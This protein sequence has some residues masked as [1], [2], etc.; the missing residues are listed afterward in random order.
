MPKSAACASVMTCGSAAPAGI[1]SWS[2]PFSVMRV[3]L[4]WSTDSS[5]TGISSPC[6]TTS[7]TATS[8]LSQQKSAAGGSSSPSDTGQSIRFAP[9]I[10]PKV[11]RA[12]NSCVCRRSGAPAEWVVVPPTVLQM[13]AGKPEKS[14]ATLQL[15]EVVRGPSQASWLN[16]FR[17]SRSRASGSPQSMARAAASGPGSP[18]RCSRFSPTTN[19]G[20]RTWCRPCR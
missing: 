14:F 4:T 2:Q 3:L 11:E 10:S 12:R 18:A 16:D 20:S 15:P 13:P 17:F 19:V 7:I 9:V 5:S 6:G 1:G 8:G